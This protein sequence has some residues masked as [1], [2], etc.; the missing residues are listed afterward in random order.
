MTGAGLGFKWKGQET[1]GLLPVGLVE[2]GSHTNVL[3]DLLDLAQQGMVGNA[4]CIRPTN[5]VQRKKDAKQEIL[6]LSPPPP[7]PASLHLG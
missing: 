5:L 4:Q 2:L 1:K 7:G 3:R 6:H